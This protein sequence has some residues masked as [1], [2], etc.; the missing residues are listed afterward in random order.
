MLRIMSDCR[1]VRLA[2]VLRD[3]GAR[4][5]VVGGTARHLAGDPREP[6]DLDVAVR[7]ADLGRLARALAT[8]GARFDPDHAARV[9][10]VRVRTT[11]G[12]L[13]VFVLPGDER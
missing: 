8:I 10:C 6:L 5:D 3:A 7:P 4:V 11:Y 1:P 13:D 2:R 12:P 9:G